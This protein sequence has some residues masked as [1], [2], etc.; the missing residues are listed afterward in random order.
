M[1]K[2]LVIFMAALSAAVLAAEQSVNLVKDGSFSQNFEAWAINPRPFG[3]LVP[4][5]GPD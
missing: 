5:A 4:K 1:K 3:K 2:F